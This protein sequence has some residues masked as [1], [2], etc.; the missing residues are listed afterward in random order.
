MKRLTY[1]AVAL[2]VFSGSAA[3]AQDKTRIAILELKADGVPARTARTVSNMLRIS[4]INTGKFHV[5]ERS[6]MDGILKEQGFQQ[7][8]CTD[9]ECAVQLGKL[10]SA[11]KILIGEVSMLG[12]V[13][14]TTV[15]LVDV[16][17]G[18]SEYAAQEKAES[19]VNLDQA[20]TMLTNKIIANIEGRDVQVVLKPPPPAPVSVKASDSEFS[21]KIIITWSPVSS[22]SKYIVYR[23]RL[24]KDDYDRLDSVKEARYEDTDAVPG[25]F[26]YYK[27]KA[28]SDS[29]ESNFSSFDKGFMNISVPTGLE[30]SS[31]DTDE[32]ELSWNS[33]KGADKYYIF[34]SDSASGSFSEIG[35]TSSASFDDQD[36]A[37]GKTVY[38]KI[39]ASAETNTTDFCSAVSGVKKI[40]VITP[41][42]YYTRGIVPG[43]GQMYAKRSTWGYAYAGAFLLTAGLALWTTM[44]FNKAKKD[45]DDLPAGTPRSEFDSKWDAYEQKALYTNIARIVLLAAYMA[46]WADLLIF[47]PEFGPV[48]AVND[49]GP[50]YFCFDVN[51]Y[52][53]Y[54][55]ADYRADFTFGLRF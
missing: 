39:K 18:L 21:D 20:V 55:R 9:Q 52:D 13:I 2:T 54:G 34:R 24:E 29:G 45:Y 44:D 53:Y 50:N 1:I 33:V 43:W 26:Y 51:S 16:E 41:V 8:G 28:A 48:T 49:T 25:R 35:S 42:G 37:P 6:Q 36:P 38:Y 14:I 7:S 27:V 12:P 31:D 4:F 47:M 46:N 10:M 3:I 22:A 32:I 40:H 30:V 15:R 11:R 19:E 5:V 17:K 23:S